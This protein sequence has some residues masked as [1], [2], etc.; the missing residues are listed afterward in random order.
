M[1]S[2]SLK[3]LG[4]TFGPFPYNPLLI[5]AFFSI[6][7][8]ARFIQVIV[9]QTPGISR[10]ATVLIMLV[11]AA[12]PSASFALATFLFQRYR[13]WSSES[14]FFYLIEVGASQSLLFLFAPIVR[15]FLMRRYGFEFKTALPLTLELFIGALVI[16]LICLSLLHRAETSIYRRLET[17]D[18]LVLQLQKDRENLILSDEELRQQVSDFLHNRVQADLMVVAMDL[19]TIKTE[20]ASDSDAVLSEA[21]ARLE[22]TRSM[23]LRNLVQV[24]SP[25]FSGAGLVEALENLKHQYGAVT[26]TQISVADAVEALTE[27]QKLGVFRI[28]EQSLLNSLVHGPAQNV[29]ISVRKA[30]RC[31]FQLCITD[32]GPGVNL[33]M[34]KPGVGSI[35]I[36]S[37]VAILKGNKEI[38]TSPENGYI[39]KVIFPAK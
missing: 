18:S 8:F 36:D 24:L 27:T 20:P 32:D 14:L 21:I 10:L 34:I 12:I 17:A 29:S 23:D 16:I 31:Q 2:H 39:L 22:K 25:N 4:R 15:K 7:Y 9:D 26:H 11:V 5:F 13:R 3:R 19:K 33:E 37:W 30:D 28:A 35:V 6:F 1:T 38:S